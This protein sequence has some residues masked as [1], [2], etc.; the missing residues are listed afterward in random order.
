MSKT[1]KEVSMPRPKMLPSD[2]AS[3]IVKERQGQYGHPA[4]VYNTVAGMWAAVF[5]WKVEAEDVALALLCVK[6]A[7]EKN[8][9]YA[10]PDEVN[11]DDMAGYANVLAMIKREAQ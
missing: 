11:V 9:A 4:D 3:E 1:D 7:R 5:G 6:I 2:R 10:N 8:S